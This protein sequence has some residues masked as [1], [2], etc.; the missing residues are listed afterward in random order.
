MVGRRF[1]VRW[2]AAYR[3][4]LP[5]TPTRVWPTTLGDAQPPYLTAEPADKPSRVTQRRSIRRRLRR[6]LEDATGRPCQWRPRQ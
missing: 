2:T 1:R 3:S 6:A 4:M 5:T